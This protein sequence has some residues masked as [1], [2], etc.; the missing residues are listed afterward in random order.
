MT[1]EGKL[2]EECISDFENIQKLW[3]KAVTDGIK[4]AN[5]MQAEQK[6]NTAENSD[7]KN[8]S[9]SKKRKYAKHGGAFSD[10]LT[11]DE[12]AKFTNAMS[13]GMDAGL[14]ISDNAILV[15]CEE[16]SDYQY[17][18]V[19]YNNE[20]EDNP[21][22]SVYAIGKIKY[23]KD[24][25]N[26]IATEIYELEMKGYVPKHAKAVLNSIAKMHKVLLGRYNYKSSSFNR[27]SRYASSNREDVGI[28]SDGTG[29]SE[30]AEQGI[31]DNKVDNDI[32]YQQRYV[33]P[34]TNALTTDG[35][36]LE[37]CIYVYENYFCGHKSSL[38]I[39]LMAAVVLY[40]P[41]V[42]VDII[43]SE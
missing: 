14:R 5:A 36:L 41:Y 13:T 34:A 24:T 37:E 11:S 25:A 8:Q 26:M 38:E 10:S 9:R 29:V 12:W 17:K 19:I 16:K 39:Y 42:I 3:D 18:L 33:E 40:L 27:I 32:E 15:E 1:T 23:N 31:S 35:K 2:L 7:V 30:N 28:E 6:N 4:T 22:K 21:L 20:I 43:D